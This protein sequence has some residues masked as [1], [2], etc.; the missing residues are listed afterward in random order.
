[1]LTRRT[2]LFTARKEME[3]CISEHNNVAVHSKIIVRYSVNTVCKIVL[4]DFSHH[5]NYNNGAFRKLDC[6]VVIR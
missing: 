4:L 3:L 2:E 5:L 6:A 1:V